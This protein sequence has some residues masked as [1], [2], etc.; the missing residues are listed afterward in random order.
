[1]LNLSKPAAYAILAFSIVCEI[2]G[3]ACLEACNGFENKKLTILLIICYFVAFSLFSKILHIIDLAVGYATWTASGAIACAVLGVVV[4]DQH[5][6]AVGWISIIVMAI[7][8]FLLNLFGTPREETAE[9]G[10]TEQ[11]EQREEK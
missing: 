4:F 7:G 9:P 6:T 8:V 1:M 10:E 5:L 11:S 2:I 3:S